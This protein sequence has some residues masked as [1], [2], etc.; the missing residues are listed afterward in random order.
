MGLEKIY[1]TFYR[2]F[3][4]NE[5]MEENN[6]DDNFKYIP[7]ESILIDGNFI[8][9]QIFYLI[10]TDLNNI[11]KVILSV[12]HN[13]NRDNLITLVNEIL[14]N[15]PLKDYKNYFE[16]IFY[17]DSL[18]KMV[19]MLRNKSLN[20]DNEG[21]KMKNI[22]SDYYLKYVKNKI[23]NLHY[24]DFI[25]NVYLIFDGVPSGFKIVEQRRR[26]FKNFLE[27]NIRKSLL[28]DKMINFPKNL[29]E[30]E[31]LGKKVIY[32]YGKFVENMITLSKSFGPSSNLFKIIGIKLR[33]FLVSNYPKVT[34]WFSGVD[35]KGEADFKILHLCRL[36]KNDNIVVHCSDFDFIILGS[37]FQNQSSIKLYLIRHF[38]KSYLVI[39]F[40]RL[41]ERILSY[42]SNSFGIKAD[43]K[44]IDDFYFSINFFGNDY[45]PP[46]NEL[47]F[48]VD[49]TFMLEILGKNIWKNN[50]FILKHDKINFDNL[51]QLFLKLND[52]GNLTFKSYLK[53]NYYCNPILRFLPSNIVNLYQF[54]KEILEIYWCEKILELSSWDDLYQKDFRMDLIQKYLPLLRKDIISKDLSE[55]KEELKN[56]FPESK[57]SNSLKV[58]LEKILKPYYA[59]TKGLKTRNQNFKFNEN[60][61]DNL[62]YF[63]YNK[64]KNKFKKLF[65]LL[66]NRS[67]ISNQVNLTDKN[68]VDD[69][70]LSL[71]FTNYKFYNPMCYSLYFYKNYTCPSISNILEYLDDYNDNTE[72]YLT[73]NFLDSNLHLILISPNFTNSYKGYE[74]FFKENP[75]LICIENKEEIISNSL[76][77]NKFNLYRDLDL[78]K[79]IISW[80]K[81]LLKI[82]NNL[83]SDKE[84]I[85]SD[86]K[87]DTKLLE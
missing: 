3:G 48:D 84:R 68:I 47:N 64:A 41:N 26:R 39:N 56:K 13:S 30:N 80:N 59:E 29:T 87:F 54:E 7:G 40:I 75:Q 52:F 27:S 16:E 32:D 81:F 35:E 22:I 70:L 60:V 45:I 4:G 19:K 33:S 67:N 1:N 9:Y 12:P 42:I 46:L 5:D 51:K 23:L 65:P 43:T 53:N 44:I 20:L 38:D 74:N 58:N 78:E 34:F 79:I 73:N 8:I 25:R 82:K 62:Y 2:L 11:L 76:L 71:S 61:Y 17:Q 31:I 18:E 69:Y 57:L 72:K 50:K 86:K 6:F 37:R 15:C 63:Y 66:E 24:Q 77:I 36:C 83:L 28:K 10:E 14:D 85:L 55:I 49:F 21:N